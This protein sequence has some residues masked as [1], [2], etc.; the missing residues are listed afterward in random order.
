MPTMRGL[1]SWLRTSR[2]TF[3]AVVLLA[4]SLKFAGSGVVQKN[5]PLAATWIGASSKLLPLAS[6]MSRLAPASGTS[7]RAMP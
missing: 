7:S 2:Y 1:P 4:T 5:N 3:P 6:T